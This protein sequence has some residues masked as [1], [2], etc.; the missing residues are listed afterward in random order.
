MHA[1]HQ[2]LTEHWSIFKTFRMKIPLFPLPIPMLTMRWLQPGFVQE[3]PMLHICSMLCL[4][5]LHRSPGII[6]AAAERNT[7]TAEL[8]CDG[9]HIH[10]ST[11]RAAFQLFGA[12]RLCLISDGM[13]A[14][15]MGNGVFCLGGQTVLVSNG[16]A[17]LENGALAGS[18]CHATGLC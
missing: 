11:V 16:C 13:A 10:P 5:F 12:D 1:L 7:V 2:S 4:L 15:G 6:G 17:K 8:I 18:V 14:T 3:Q 9:I